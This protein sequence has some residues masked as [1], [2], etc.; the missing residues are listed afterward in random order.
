MHKP[1]QGARSGGAGRRE[2]QLMFAVLLMPMHAAYQG[3]TTCSSRRRCPADT[4]GL[5]GRTRSTKIRDASRGVA[6]PGRGGT[7]LRQ[8]AAVRG[9]V[10]SGYIPAPL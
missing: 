10:E 5:N 1:G 2:Q 8:P 9:H 4:H 3:Q 6:G 7:S